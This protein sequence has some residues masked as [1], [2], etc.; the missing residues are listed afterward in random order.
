MTHLRDEMTVWFNGNEDAI[1]LAEL[2]FNLAQEWDDV[3][4]DG[5]VEKANNVLSFL[6]F[7]LNWQP[8]FKQFDYLLRPALLVCYLN[9]RDATALETGTEADL[10][11]AFMLRA[12]IYDVFALMAWIIGGEVH[13]QQ[14]GP[15]IRRAYGERLADYLMEHADA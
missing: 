9:W 6:A 1:E 2:L 8:F 15:A 5:A 7:R 14:V 10:E 3:I 12:G 11:K 4:D 13:S